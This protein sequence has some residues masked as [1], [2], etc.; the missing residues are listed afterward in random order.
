VA[1]PRLV[2]TFAAA[3]GHTPPMSPRVDR[4]TTLAAIDATAWNALAGDN[5]FLRH[6][7]LLALEETGCVGEGTAWHPSYLVAR[8]EQGVSGAMPLYIKYDSHGEFVF[9]WTWAD[10]YERS[11]RPYYPKLVAAVP[12]TP[13]TGQRLLLRPASRATSQRRCSMR[14]ATSPKTPAQSLTC[15]FRPSPSF[16]C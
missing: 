1:E 9:D 14:R 3:P 10:A 16:R 2:S 6:E 7:F 5:P 13:A 15:C 12:F 11:G 4:L 8:D